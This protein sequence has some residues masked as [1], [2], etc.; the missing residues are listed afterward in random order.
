MLSSRRAFLQSAAAVTIGFHG[1]QRLLAGGTADAPPPADGFGPLEP[2]PQGILDLP[3]GFSYQV[4]SRV[5]ESME[6]GL[7]VP[8][9]PDG[10][11]AFPGPKGRTIL[12]RN[13]ELL[14]DRVKIGPYGPK[15]ELIK[16]IPIDRLYDPGWNR[17][18]CIGG[19]TTLVYSTAERKLERQF[20][21]LAGTQYN[22]A[23]GPTPW[24]SW[25]TCEENTQRSDE[26]YEKDH[27]YAF[28]VPA[29]A[30]IGLAQPRPLRAM[31]RFRREAVAVD[32]RSGIVYQTEDLADGVIYRFIPA[33]PG[34]LAA[35]GKL[36]AL[37]VRDKKS[38]DTRNW[39]EDGTRVGPEFPKSQQLAVE[40]TDLTDVEAPED[41]LRIRAFAAGAARFARA[42]GMWF[43]RDAVYWAC[44]NGGRIKAGQIFRYVPSPQEGTPGERRA[45]GTLELFIE[46]NDSNLLENADNVTMAPWGDLILCED[47]PKQQH[48]VGVTPAGRLYHFA[49]NAA[50]AFEFAGACFS[51]E[52]STLFVNV[53]G[54]GR[55][56]AITGPWRPSGPRPG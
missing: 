23:G 54:A 52:G 24:G 14:S 48:I 20:L 4:I 27:G 29:S 55:T 43:G 5:G 49:R 10:M 36:Q 47:G 7:L 32:P 42:E 45:P 37:G 22:C 18:P 16:K 35:G 6:D 1:L 8:G 17:T 21:S 41:D 19:T 50:D 56:F 40:W 3:R 46:P 28:E 30:E 53:Q 39:E 33:Q 31:G 25:I 13:H 2:D 44:T 38:L 26:Q 12:V 15:N 11:A 34:R 51:P 9:K